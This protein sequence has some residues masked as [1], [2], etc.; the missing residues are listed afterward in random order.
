[1][2][3]LNESPVWVAGIYQLEQTDPVVAG[4]DGI[5]NLQAKQ[6]ANRTSFLKQGLEAAQQDLA[7]IGIDG[8]NASL[9]AIE[10]ALNYVGLL[11]KEAQRDR[12]VR[13]QEGEFIIYNRGIK[14]GCALSKSDTANRNLNIS[15]GTIFMHGCE[16]P[17]AAANNAA[18]VPANASGTTK[19]AK[20]YLINISGVLKLGVT[21]LGESEPENSLVLASIS[22]PAGNT[23]ATD[24]HLSSVT[25]T[26]TARTE[27][28]WPVTQINPTYVQQSLAR[29]MGSK[30]YSLGLDVLS[31]R[32]GEKPML[33][34][35][36]SDR[37]TN[38][39]RV[40]LG[41]SADAV[42]VRY[43]ALLMNQ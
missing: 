12:T 41:G 43:A 3:N 4:P 42:R 1:M 38:T 11:D 2:A 8:Q 29:V 6:L 27:K 28:D 31:Y 10:Y 39:F 13:H 40:Y 17:V 24:P 37:S 23:G 30:N 36:S 34:K 7:A 20:A 22:V 16:M 14:Y 15:G 9:S 25:I 18:S 32:G 5:D 21:G 19:T 26:V 35:D 33:V